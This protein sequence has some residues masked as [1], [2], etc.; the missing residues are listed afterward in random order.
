MATVLYHKT[1]GWFIAY[2]NAGSRKL[3]REY[4][5][6]TE[7]GKKQAKIRLAEVGLMKLKGGTLRN[8]SHMYLDELAQHYLNNA[9]LKKKTERW[10]H[11]F[12][13][14]LN[15]DIL[16]CLCSK[17]VDNLNYKDILRL[18]DADENGPWKE[19]K[20]V[21]VGRYLGYL[22][23]V[24]QFGIDKEFTEKNPLRTWK[25]LVDVP[26]KPALTF[27]DF[28]RIISNAAPHLA[29]A[30]EV[31]WYLGTR[32]GVSEL[33]SIKWCDVNINNKEIHI[34]GTKTKESDRFIPLP[35]DFVSR[36]R[37][38]KTQATSEYVVDYK[39]HSVRQLRRSFKAACNRADIKYDI[40]P[41]DVRH[42]F[43]SVILQKGG[44]L[45]AVSKLLGHSRIETTQ[46]H[47]YHLMSGEKKRSVGLLP[48]ITPPPPIQPVVAE[49][50]HVA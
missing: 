15:K 30:L 16:P 21:T 31:E 49:I 19:K 24:F 14:L 37:A 26:R 28:Q 11:E 43:A 33:F 38:V 50:G 23:A 34:R 39:G 6:N 46:R 17:P 45:A 4:F 5:G 29:W 32:P 12:A 41:Y 27:E 8:S 25:R 22:R 42:L 47:Y 35:E 44:D 1:G 18:T 13:S 40:R 3:I 9:K 7:D 2:R 36:L 48:V 20:A 10:R